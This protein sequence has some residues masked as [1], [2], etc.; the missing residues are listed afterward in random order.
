[1]AASTANILF[2]KSWDDQ[3]Q[4]P[5]QKM[6]LKVAVNSLRSSQGNRNQPVHDASCNRKIRYWYELLA[7]VYRY[8]REIFHKLISTTIMH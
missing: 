6:F 8:Y 5:T 7:S 2:Y 4:H 3:G 1:M